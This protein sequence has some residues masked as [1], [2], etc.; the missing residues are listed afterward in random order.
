MANEVRRLTLTGLPG[1]TDGAPAGYTLQIPLEGDAFHL[2]DGAIGWSYVGIDGVTGPLSVT[3]GADPTS[4]VDGYDLYVP[5]P[6]AS[7]LCLGTF[8]FL[9]PGTGSFYLRMEE[10]DGTEAGSQVVRPGS[11]VNLGVLS[12]GTGPPKIGQTW[13]PSITTPAVPTPVLDFIAISTTPLPPVSCGLRRD[14]G[15]FH[16]AQPAVLVGPAVGQGSPFALPFPLNCD[17]I[18]VA[19]TCQAGQADAGGTFGLTDAIDFVIGI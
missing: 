4:T 14:P 16:F 6:A 18:G 5:A 7:G 12:L 13:D 17:T 10:D 3:V 11:G 8:T 19:L 9:T 15:D 1:S 2:N